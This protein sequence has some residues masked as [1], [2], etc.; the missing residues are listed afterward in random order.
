MAGIADEQGDAVQAEALYKEALLL[1]ERIQGP[2][3]V[4]TALAL[5]KYAR[6]LREQA[7]YD[8]AERLYR[9]ALIIYE[10]HPD[11]ADPADVATVV[12]N[13]GVLYLEQKDYAQAE[14][15]LRR[16]ITLRDAVSGREH[17][18]LATCL[19]NLARCYQQQNDKVLAEL[20]FQRALEIYERAWGASHPDT[21]AVKASLSSLRP[22]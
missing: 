13:L 7:T 4:K 10:Q 8:E 15:T 14:A 22:T 9:R 3:H 6:F 21:L 19:G 11:D 12:N 2:E 5:S 1:S 16:A 17:P 20:L 18:N